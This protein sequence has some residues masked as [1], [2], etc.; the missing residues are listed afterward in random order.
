MASS[1]KPTT[2]SQFSELCI[3]QA[4]LP[5]VDGSHHNNEISLGENRNH[6]C[7]CCYDLVELDVL[8]HS[9]PA[10]SQNPTQI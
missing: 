9:L 8:K 2:A 3:D 5:L 1:L 4:S 7:L 10:N 6:Y